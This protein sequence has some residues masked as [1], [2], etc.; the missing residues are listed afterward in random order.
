MLL[1]MSPSMNGIIEAGVVSN[2]HNVINL[3]GRRT[4]IHHCSTAFTAA[5]L[6]TCRIMKGTMSKRAPACGM[7]WQFGSLTPTMKV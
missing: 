6:C 1:H 4:N 5:F 2:K 7:D 3:H